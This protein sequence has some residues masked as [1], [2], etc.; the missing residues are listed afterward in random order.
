MLEEIGAG[1]LARVL[2][3]LL[4]KEVLLVVSASQQ[5]HKGKLLNVRKDVISIQGLQGPVHFRWG[6][7][8]YVLLAEHAGSIV[9]G[10]GLQ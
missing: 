3:P 4:G 9:R 8:D 5:G 6:A 1:G 2:E 10:G 7:L